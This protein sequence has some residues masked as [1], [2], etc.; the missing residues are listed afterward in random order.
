[1]FLLYFIVLILLYFFISFYFSLYYLPYCIHIYFIIVSK[2]YLVIR[3]GV[4]FL[5]KDSA[6]A[7]WFSL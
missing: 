6:V 4:F 5:W 1:L 7:C 3:V 2:V